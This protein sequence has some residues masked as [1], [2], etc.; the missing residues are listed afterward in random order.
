MGEHFYELSFLKQNTQSSNKGSLTNFITLKLRTLDH[1]KTTIKKMKRQVTMWK[2]IFATHITNKLL[3]SR[4][5]KNV[6]RS[7]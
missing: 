5:H 4:S 3:A 6:Y 7:I 2:K 1:Q